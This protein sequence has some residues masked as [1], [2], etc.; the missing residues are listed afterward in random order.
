MYL[1]NIYQKFAEKYPDVFKEYNELG[2]SCRKAGP[3]NAKTQDL[4]KL[5]IA[6][7]CN[8]RGGVMSHTRKALAAG[9][10]PEEIFHAILLSLTTIGFPNMMAAMSWVNEVVEEQPKK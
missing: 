2:A 3:L 1:P 5:G 9:A 8:S 7:G 10:T 4:V 6:M